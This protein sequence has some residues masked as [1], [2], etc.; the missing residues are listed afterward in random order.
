MP[1]LIKVGHSTK[2]P[3]LRARELNNTGIPHPYIVEYEMLIEEPF[4]IEQQTHKALNRVRENKEWFRC[5]CEEAIAAIQRVAGGSVINEAFKQADR[6]QAERIRKGQEKAELRI[7]IVNEQI[8]KQE[9]AVETKYRDI[10]ASQFS[11]RPFWPYW[12]ASSVGVFVL[13]AVVSPKTA[14]SILFASAGIF[15]AIVAFVAR[16]FHESRRKE[17]PP[18]KSLQQ[19]KESQLN[20]ARTGIVLA[21]RNQSCQLRIRF[22]VDMLNSSVSGAWTCPKCKTGINPFESLMNQ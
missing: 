18:Y 17:S 14:D 5:S 7:R 11:A 20:E 8:K 4:R 10:F 3:E 13:I 22:G 6:E 9:L 2:D 15:G 16:E 19:E 12:I 21:C 1:G